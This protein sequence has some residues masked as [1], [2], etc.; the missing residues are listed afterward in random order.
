MLRR[1]IER[2]GRWVVAI[3]LLMV[4]GVASGAYILTKRAVHLAVRG[5]L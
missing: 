4:I 2:Y 1:Q 5:P 3:A